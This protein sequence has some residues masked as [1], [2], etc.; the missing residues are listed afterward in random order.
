MISYSIVA[1]LAAV[2]TLSSASRDWPQHQDRSQF[3]CPSDWKSLTYSKHTDVYNPR[4]YYEC[5]V[6]IF[7]YVFETREACPEYAKFN[8]STHE[9]E[10]ESKPDHEPEFR[11]PKNSH[12]LPYNRYPY[13][14]NP[15]KYY[16]CWGSQEGIGSSAAVVTT[17]EDCPEYTEFNQNIHNC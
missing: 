5:A 4:F 12:N 16:Y 14:G 2:A 11:C 6:N 17:V 7:G 10:Y 9:C 15:R 13:K 3:K 1:T 8:E